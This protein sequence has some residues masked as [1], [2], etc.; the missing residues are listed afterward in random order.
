MK[1]HIR[2]HP[3]RRSLRSDLRSDKGYTVVNF[4]AQAAIIPASSRSFTDTISTA[5]AMSLCPGQN[6]DVLRRVVISE[7]LVGR[8]RARSPLRSAT[9]DSAP[10]RSA[11]KTAPGVLPT[12]RKR[13]WVL[14]KAATERTDYAN[15]AGMGA[16]M[17]G[18]VAQLAHNGIAK[19]ASGKA[20]YK[21]HCVRGFLVEKSNTHKK[22][23]GTIADHNWKRE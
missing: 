1:E 4:N 22:P 15:R 23:D 21:M 6:R 3:N 19:L 2:I 11:F 17:F 14:R 5:P 18:S 8:E 20:V 9:S 10:A 12:L 13:A 7:R 16:M